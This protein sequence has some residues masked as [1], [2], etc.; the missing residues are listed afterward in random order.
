[1]GLSFCGVSL[2][3]PKLATKLPF[4]G[5]ATSSCHSSALVLL[6]ASSHAESPRAELLRQHIIPGS[7]FPQKTTSLRI[8]SLMPSFKEFGNLKSNMDLNW[9]NSQR[10]F[11]SLN[12]LEWLTAVLAFWAPFFSWKGWVSSWIQLSINEVAQVVR[13]SQEEALTCQVLA[14]C[15]GHLMN[16]PA[17]FQGWGW[18]SLM[19]ITGY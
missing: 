12:N 10:S 11:N 19:A 18:H 5:I 6:W 1:M 14:S 13:S 3:H 2:G 8:R 17:V 9:G 7:E 4:P 15:W 16:D